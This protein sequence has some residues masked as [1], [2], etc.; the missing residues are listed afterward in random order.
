MHRRRKLK[1][2]NQRQD[3]RTVQLVQSPLLALIQSPPNGRRATNV[4]T[5]LVSRHLASPMLLSCC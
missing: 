2:D 5:A 4:Y 1:K 3:S